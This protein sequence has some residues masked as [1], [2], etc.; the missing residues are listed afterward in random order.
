MKLE[1]H[2]L[3]LSK[4]K[5]DFLKAVQEWKLYEV[6]DTMEANRACPCGK[7]NLRFLY[8]IKN[9]ITKESTIVGKECIKC[10]ASEM[11]IDQEW[12]FEKDLN[13]QVSHVALKSLSLTGTYCGLDKYQRPMFI[14]HAN[15][16]IV[17]SKK[18]LENHFGYTPV[19]KA[20]KRWRISTVDMR[21]IK[22]VLKQESK[23]KLSLKLDGKSRSLQLQL[24][25]S[26]E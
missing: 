5:V 8:Y 16:M 14:I 17:K 13:Q 25:S 20:G 19:Y 2:I 12:G 23:Y 26:T 10:F 21:S 9:Q 6:E 22:N 7:K 11:E 15:S 1:Q 18:T 4:E 3:S 24:R